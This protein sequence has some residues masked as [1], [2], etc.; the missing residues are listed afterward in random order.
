MVRHGQEWGYHTAT[1]MIP[2]G[3]PQQPGDKGGQKRYLILQTGMRSEHRSNSLRANK[4]V[5]A[6]VEPD[7]WFPNPYDAGFPY[8]IIALHSHRKMTIPWMLL[9]RSLLK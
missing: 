5:M 1:F 9:P 3:Y 7:A 8:S 6:E 2:Y 4:W